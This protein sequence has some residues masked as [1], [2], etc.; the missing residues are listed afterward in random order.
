MEV[1]KV[2]EVTQEELESSND[3]YMR[4]LEKIRNRCACASCMISFNKAM[5]NL[6]EVHE[7]M[8]QEAEKRLGLQVES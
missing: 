6:Q 3:W 4:E 2:P 5:K 7:Q 1:L 8:D